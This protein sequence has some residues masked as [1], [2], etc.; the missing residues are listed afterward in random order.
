M[1]FEDIWDENNTAF[2]KRYASGRRFIVNECWKFEMKIFDGSW[3]IANFNKHFNQ[4][5]QTDGRTGESQ[6]ASRI[7][8]CRGHKKVP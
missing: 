7:S 2:N 3:D 8:R 6:Y 4:A 5:L 1:D